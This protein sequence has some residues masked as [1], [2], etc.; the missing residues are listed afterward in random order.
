MHFVDMD[1]FPELIKLTLLT[2]YNNH[3]EELSSYLGKNYLTCLK[4]IKSLNKYFVLLLQ[5]L[6]FFFV[7]GFALHKLPEFYSFSNLG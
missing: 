3:R 4:T 2:K 6:F 5:L 7:C 1:G